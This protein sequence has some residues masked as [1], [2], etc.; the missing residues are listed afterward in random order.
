ML[1]AMPAIEKITSLQNERVK[2]VVKMHRGKGRSDQGQMVV[3]GFREIKMALEN[4]FRLL[5]LFVCPDITDNSD[6]PLISQLI[7][8][9]NY[10]EVSRQVFEK[11]AYR[12]NVDGLLAV[13]QTKSPLLTELKLSKNPLIV[14]LEAVEKPGN[15]GAVLRTA[16]AAGVDAVIV[17]EPQ[18][19]V[20][21]PNTIRSS[22][23]AVFS[24]QVASASSQET[25]KWLQH[26]N[27]IPFAAV[28]WAKDFHFQAKLDG[29]VALIMGAEATGL[30]DFWLTNVKD[31]LK[32]PMR[33][34]IDSLNVSTSTAILVYEALRQRLVCDA[35]IQ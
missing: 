31:H 10:T 19:D 12:E 3:E 1:C 21:N 7:S 14:V 32:I 27:I 33:G 25:L 6:S 26:E 22:L 28:T 35:V 18:T 29:P 34:K 9:Q 2:A 17:C 11:M 4:G 30:S 20:F 16:D 23:G 8:K 24:V 13:M 5:S 15:L